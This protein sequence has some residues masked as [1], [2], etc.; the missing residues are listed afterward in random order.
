ML[1]VAVLCTIPVWWWNW[2]HGWASAAQ[3]ENRGKLHGPFDLHFSTF[4]GFLELQSLVISP[5]LFLALL[6]TAVGVATRRLGGRSAAE[7]EGDL[8]LLF[9]FLPV[10]LLYAVLAWHFRGEP[11]WPAVSYLGLIIVLASR[12][13]EILASRPARLFVSA[14]F[15]LAWLQTVLLHDPESIPL[16]QKMDPMGRVIGWGQIADHLDQLRHDQQADVLIADAYKEAA[17][18]SFHLPD[19]AFIYT[20]RHWPP[21]NQYDFWPGYG[22]LTQPP[23][24]ALWITGEPTPAALR[25]DF[26]TITPLERVVVSFRGR[27]FREYTIYRCE[28]K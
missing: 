1:A 23:H 4:L 16:S 20:L 24:R 14:A 21:A 3:L 6:A 17:I 5:L 12:W 28:N 15:V 19:H 25:R 18:F 7:S 8:L 13:R 26:N 10:F 11:N 27:P 22:D 2:Q 9:L